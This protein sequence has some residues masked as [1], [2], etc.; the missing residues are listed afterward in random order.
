VAKKLLFKQGL[1]QKSYPTNPIQQNKFQ[2]NF[3]Y[4]T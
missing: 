1:K 3:L 2:N 4:V